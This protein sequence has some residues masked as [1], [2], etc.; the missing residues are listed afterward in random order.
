MPEPVESAE[1]APNRLRPAPLTAALLAL[2]LLLPILPAAVA[3]AADSAQGGN[4]GPSVDELVARVT[5]GLGGE[6]A[7]QEARY[8]T[9]EFAGRRSHWWDRYTG[10]HRMEGTTREGARYVVLENVHD[11]GKAG[12]AWLDGKEVTGDDGAMMVQHAY[13]AWVNDT[14][15]LISPYKLRDP[16]V[17]LEAA[18]KETVDGVTYD[19]LHLSFDHVG[20]TPG[21]QYWMFINPTTGRVDRWQYVLESQEPPPTVWRWIDWKQYGPGIWLSSRRDKLGDEPV[22]LTLGPIEVPKSLPESVFTS[23]EPLK[24]ADRGD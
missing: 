12:R 1:P 2:A 3:R 10:R 9:F 14:F 4:A 21:D 16:G 24:A 15:W 8:I 11:E 6:Q 22:E 13:A 5:A 7:W 18:G 17:H 23:P 19:K 20:L